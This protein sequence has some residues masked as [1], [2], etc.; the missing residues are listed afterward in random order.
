MDKKEPNY[1]EWMVGGIEGPYVIKRDEIYFM[2]FSTWTRGYEL[3]LLRSPT[4]F[5]PWELVSREPIFGT[6]KKR[7]R[8]EL[9]LENGYADLQFTDT[10]DPFCETGHNAL[11]TGPDGKLWSSCHYMLCD[12]DGE[13]KARLPQLG[14]EPVEYKNGRFYIN[15]PTWTPQVIRY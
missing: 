2:F 9:A 3:G 14:Y 7:Y 15:G 5:G 11:F 13:F 10:P 6:R 12:Q 8:P 1:P 4:P